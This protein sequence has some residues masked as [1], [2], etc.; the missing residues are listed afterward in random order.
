V[1][2]VLK[3][4]SQQEFLKRF[5][6]WRH[7]WAKCIGC[8]RAVLCRWPLTAKCKYIG[9]RL[10]IKSFWE[11][12]SH[13]SYNSSP[14]TGQSVSQSHTMGYRSGFDSQQGIFFPQS[15]SDRLWGTPS[16]LSNGYRGLFPW[17]GSIAR[18]WSRY[19]APLSSAEVKNMWRFNST[20]HTS[21]RR[22]VYGQE[23]ICLYLVLLLVTRTHR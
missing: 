15:R 7:R 21:S 19:Y 16:F 14:R 1:A 2:K 5:Q 20:T 10:A 9:T 6:Q 17:R 18:M 12:H 13:T 11:L 3:V 4:I 23:I 8:S 22:S